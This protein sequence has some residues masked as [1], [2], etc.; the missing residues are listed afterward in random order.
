MDNNE[1]LLF[2][3]KCLTLRYYPEKVR[4][5][6]QIIQSGDIPWEKV[7]WNSSNQ[8]VLPAMFVHLKE[9]ELLNELPSG[10]ANYL[11]YLY[12]LN[13]D[14][15]SSIINQANKI[16]TLLNK[17]DIEPI[18][19]K[20]TGN[21]LIDLYQDPGERMIGDIDILVEEE[22]MFAASDILKN[23]G[24]FD[25]SIYYK[26]DISNM[27]HYPRL[28]NNG[29]VA[30][31]EIHRQVIIPPYHRYLNSHSLINKKER[32]K[33]NSKA[34]SLSQKHS[35]IYNMMNVVIND[36][37]N[38]MGCILMRQSYDLFLLSQKHDI[39]SISNDFGRFQIK[40]NNYIALTS[41][42]FD[43]PSNINY[44]NN[45]VTRLH[46]KRVFMLNNYPWLSQVNYITLFFRTRFTRYLSLCTQLFY[47]KEVRKSIAWKLSRWSWYKSHLAT[48]KELLRKTRGKI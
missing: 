2:I 25:D 24:Y 46:I 10:L 23:E 32:L 45:L 48:Y 11:H 30:A 38:Y 27:K 1:T 31:V 34:Y 6:R 15:N 35:V 3:G 16:T 42:L 14:R 36:K 28:K 13:Y 39:S 20:G 5:I 43:N 47:K 40:C 8:M 22:N 7:V 37:A 4:I 26:G 29:E 21:L 44:K 17:N 18:F 19:L 33:G 12:Q 9:V 41:K